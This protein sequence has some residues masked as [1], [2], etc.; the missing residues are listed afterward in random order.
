MPT[1]ARS[2]LPGSTLAAAHAC[3]TAV[4][5]AWRAFRSPTRKTLLPEE[6]PS[7]NTDFSSPTRHA[8][9]VPPPSIPRKIPTKLVLS[10]GSICSRHAR[11]RAACEARNDKIDTRK[12]EFIAVGC[13]PIPCQRKTAGLYGTG[14]NRSRHY[15]VV[16]G[17]HHIVRPPL[18]QA[19]A[20]AARLLPRRSEH[21]MVGHIS[22]YCCSGDQHAYDHQ[23]SWPGLRH[24]SD[25]LAG[26]SRISSGTHNHQLR[27]TSPVFSWRTLYSV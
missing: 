27:S 8:V 23:H 9:L 5:I 10:H 3:W 21:S 4:V 17:G 19:P 7:P 25:V 12:R 13:K 1:Q 26:G 14:S 16:S 11:P 15:S 22:V 20:I 24:E 2:T 18:S 6:A